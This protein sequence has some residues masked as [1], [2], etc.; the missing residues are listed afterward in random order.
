LPR[1]A[2]D[3]CESFRFELGTYERKKLQEIIDEQRKFKITKISTGA[4][5]ILG[6]GFLAVSIGVLGFFMAPN[7]I[8]ELKEKIQIVKDAVDKTKKNASGLNEDGSYATVLCVGYTDARQWTGE[9]SPNE[10]RVVVNTTSG[11]PIIGSLTAA[12]LYVITYIAEDEEYVGIY[13]N[14]NKDAKTI[15]EL[16]DPWYYLDPKTGGPLY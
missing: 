12:G 16:S 3:S 6:A 5:V 7:I 14:K 2:P 10:G 1:L 13:G 9:R 11:F 15:E 8:E 4:G